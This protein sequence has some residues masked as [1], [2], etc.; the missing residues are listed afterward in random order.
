MNNLNVPIVVVAFDRVHSLARILA[1]LDRSVYPSQV[2]LIISIDGGGPE[3][4]FELATH[5]QWRHGEKE[6]ICQP[7]NLGLRAHILKCGHLALKYDG[8]VLLEDD[9]YVSAYFYQF[10]LAAQT[11]YANDLNISGVALYSP[12]YSETACLPFMPIEDGYDVFFMQLACSWG[13]SWLSRQWHD[14]ETWYE[15]TKTKPFKKT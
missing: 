8:I 5:F 7:E 2:K 4:V 6:I 11:R 13:Q 15:K 14:F 1:S 3:E 10:M 12:R 9:I